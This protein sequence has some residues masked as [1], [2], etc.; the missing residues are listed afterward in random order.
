MINDDIHYQQYNNN[1]YHTHNS[2]SIKKRVD[3]V[4][5]GDIIFSKGGFPRYRY[6]NLDLAMIIVGFNQPN[7]KKGTCCRA[8][9]LES[10]SVEG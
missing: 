10:T 8:G 6:F 5:G 2:I 7:Q 4:Q 9:D 1:F 3:E